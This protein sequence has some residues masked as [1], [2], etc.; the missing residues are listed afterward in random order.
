[1]AKCAECGYLAV[2]NRSTQELRDVSDQWRRTGGI[3]ISG[4]HECC[5][6]CFVKAFPIEDE[7]RGAGSAEQDRFLQVIKLERNCQRFISWQQGLSPKEHREMDLQ[8]KLM[9]AQNAI[10]RESQAREDA[11]H[12]QARRWQLEDRAWQEEWKEKDRAWQE[13][14]ERKRWVYST[15]TTLAGAVVGAVAGAA[16]AYWLKR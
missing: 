10:R 6:Y 3:P 4:P 14:M 12:E 9:E 13:G 5:P 2:L 8:A 7:M 11:I 1:M 16:L 15:F